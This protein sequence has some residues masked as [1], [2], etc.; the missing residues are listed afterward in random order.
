[1]ELSTS[2]P[3]GVITLPVAFLKNYFKITLKNLQSRVARLQIH[4]ADSIGVTSFNYKLNHWMSLERQPFANFSLINQGHL[5]TGKI[6]Y[7]Q[8][9][10]IFMY[11][12][13]PKSAK[14]SS[15]VESFAN[16]VENKLK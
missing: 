11:L 14:L 5:I 8:S 13:L 7:L 2:T 15:T 4:T 12:I 6:Y 1:M 9:H 10:G 16:E 3:L